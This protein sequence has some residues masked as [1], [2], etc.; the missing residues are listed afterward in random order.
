M[1]HAV[2]AE[3]PPQ[4]GSHTQVPQAASDGLLSQVVPAGQPPPQLVS[5]THSPAAA[6]QTSVD[7]Q[8][9]QQFGSAAHKPLP[10]LHT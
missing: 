4:F 6:L 1:G 7:L 3:A 5:H 9:P 2:A 8:A 10:E